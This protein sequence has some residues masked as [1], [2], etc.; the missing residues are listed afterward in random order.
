MKVNINDMVKVRLTDE[1]RRLHR[2]NHDEFVNGIKTRSGKPITL[3][4]DAPKEDTDGWSRW[5]L[6]SLM[7]EFGHHMSLG[8]NPP[9]ETEIEVEQTRP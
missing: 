8:R 1:G 5:Q 4:Y 6:W 2:A 3:E 9:F 7:Q